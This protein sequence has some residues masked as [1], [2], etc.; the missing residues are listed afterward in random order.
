LVAADAVAA[1]LTTIAAQSASFV[2]INIF[3]SW[4]VGGDRCSASGR[5]DV[6]AS[7]VA[8]RMGWCRRCRT[9]R[10]TKAPV[11]IP[12]GGEQV[13]EAT[14]MSVLAV[15]IRQPPAVPLACYPLD[16]P[17]SA[18][19]LNGEKPAEVPVMRPTRFQLLIIAKPPKRSDPPCRRRCWPR[20]INCL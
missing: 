15:T 10:D 18:R 9:G 13:E 4:F 1:V 2:Q 19:I 8:P 7:Y 16:G 5:I 12:A 14:R 17:G 3:V 6:R 20:P 11:S